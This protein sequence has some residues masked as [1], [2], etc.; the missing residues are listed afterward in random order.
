MNKK[1][2]SL[3]VAICLVIGLLPIISGAEATSATVT[4]WG[5]SVSVDTDAG[6]DTPEALYW[7]NPA[8]AGQAPVAL[9]AADAWN[10]CFSI[11]NGV[12]TV[13]LNGAQYTYVGVFYR[14]T[15]WIIRIVFN[16]LKNILHIC[17][18]FFI[19]IKYNIDAIRHVI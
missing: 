17:S 5:T 16:L 14:R 1:F 4:L 12:P 8:E 2:I 10:Y 9:T 11:I 6:T 13:M 19:G 3:L 7:G 18:C 15:E